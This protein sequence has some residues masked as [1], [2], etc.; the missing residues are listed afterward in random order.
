MRWAVLAAGIVMTLFAFQNRQPQTTSDFTLFYR[1]AER[2]AAA[3]Y[4]RPAG[5]PRGNMNPPHFHFLIEPLT[6]LPIG[7]AAVV[8]RTLNIA[9]LAA[10][11]WFL[12][13]SAAE[14]WGVADVGAVLA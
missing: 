10:C 5:T 7:M 13:R 6:A 1:S 11:L 14:K 4:E 9:S 2:P 8:W 12:R 3:M